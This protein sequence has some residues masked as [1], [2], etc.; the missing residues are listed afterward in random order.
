MTD[1]IDELDIHEVRSRLFDLILVTPDAELRQLL[2]ELKKRQESRLANMREHYR[3]DVSIEVDCLADEIKCQDSI[4]NISSGGIFIQTDEK[5]S[6]GQKIMVTFSIPKYKFDNKITLV[7]EVVR[8]EPSGI[9]VKFN[10]PVPHI[11]I[12]G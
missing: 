5:F 12:D 2:E 3:E 11:G 4:K 8:I 9:G 7:G 6:M 1:N 10:E